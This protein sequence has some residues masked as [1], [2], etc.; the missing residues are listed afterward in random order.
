MNTKR[1]GD[2]GRKLPDSLLVEF[3]GDYPLIRVLDFLIENRIFDYSKK[4]ICK[5]A[6]VSWN[7]LEDFWSGLEKKS[8]VTYTRKVGKA[9]LYKL[10]IANPAANQL[11]ELD[12]M[13]MKQAM[14]KIGEEEPVKAMARSR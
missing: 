12:K 1:A 7:T 11:I 2:R 4:D 13:L 3:L 5:Y 9:S 10:N 14:G 8:L 6:E